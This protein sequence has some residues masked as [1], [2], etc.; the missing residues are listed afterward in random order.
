[1]NMNKLLG[2]TSVELSIPREDRVAHLEIWRPSIAIVDHAGSAARWW[3][4]Y[5][6]YEIFDS[7]KDL[8]EVTRYSLSQP[9]SCVV[10]HSKSLMMSKNMEEHCHLLLDTGVDGILKQTIS[11]NVCTRWLNKA[12]LILSVL[13]TSTSLL[14]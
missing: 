14:L 7:I 10:N 3:L 5:L 2:I 4:D 9:P 6:S 12:L 13:T 8:P 1:M 11:L